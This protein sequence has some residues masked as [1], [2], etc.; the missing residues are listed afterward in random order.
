MPL[1]GGPS[2]LSAKRMSQNLNTLCVSCFASQRC[3]LWKN[4]KKNHHNSKRTCH[5]KFWH[6]AL[7]LAYPKTYMCRFSSLFEHFFPVQIDIFSFFVKGSSGNSQKFHIWLILTGKNV[8][9]WL[10]WCICWVWGMPN[11][12]VQVLSPYNKQF[13]KNQNFRQKFHILL[14]FDWEECIEMAWVAH[15]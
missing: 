12:V 6:S 2:D 8:L 4:N 7:Q 5:I 10:E 9:K 15:I 1:L 11:P 14:I 13:L 3:F